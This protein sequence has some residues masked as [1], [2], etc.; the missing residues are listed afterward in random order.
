[1][2]Q[3]PSQS[4]PFI[5]TVHSAKGGVGK[6][7]LVGN[8]SVA[9]AQKGASV[10]VIDMDYAS[11]GLHIIFG[12]PKVKFSLEDVLEGRCTLEQAA[13]RLTKK[14]DLRGRLILI[15]SSGEAKDMV[16]MQRQ[17]YD[18]LQVEKLT[19]DFSKYS[20]DYIILDARHGVSLPSLLS[21]AVSDVVLFLARLDKQDVAGSK[22]PLQVARALKK[23]T[24]LVACM[25]SRDVENGKMR[26]R[27]GLM[28]GLPLAAVLPYDPQVQMNRSSG[29]FILKKPKGDYAQRINS[30]ADMLIRMRAKFVSR[31]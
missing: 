21:I 14:L 4:P 11:P 9:L 12:L 1:M 25:I 23:H 27:L 22:A 20:L 28:F 6:T 19:K 24:I 2:T 7:N 10:G 31:K 5:I 18:I 3:P 16:N 26:K 15:P 13:I 8:L 29:A 17:R 30:M